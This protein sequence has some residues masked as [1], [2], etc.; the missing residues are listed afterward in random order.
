MQEEI[1]ELEA[2]VKCHKCG[3]IYAVRNPQTGVPS[4]DNAGVLPRK[5]NGPSRETCGGSFMFGE[6]VWVKQKR[7]RP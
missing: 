1:V 2:K 5:H 6:L 3:R 7:S 4:I